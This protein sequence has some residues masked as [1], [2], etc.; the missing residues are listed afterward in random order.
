MLLVKLSDGRQLKCTYYHN[1]LLSVNYWGK[2]KL[3]KANELKIG[4]KIAKYQFPTI[5]SGENFNQAYS[6]GFYS[7]EGNENTKTVWIYEPKFICSKRLDGKL[8]ES[9]YEI[10]SG[11]KRKQF[12]LSFNPL[13]KDYV[14]LN[15]DLKSKINWLSGLFDGDGCELK[16]GGLQLVSVNKNFLLELQK[17]LSL[18]GTQCKVVFGSDEQYRSMP[19]GHGGEKQYLCKE[20]WRICIGAQQV[21][22]LSSLGLKCERLKFNK[23]P[24]RDASQFVKIVSIEALVYCFNE[25]I[26]HLGCF[27]GIVTG[28]CFEIGF[29]P[30]TNDGICGVMFCNLTSQNAAKIKTKVDWKIAI[31]A[32][33]IIGTLQAGYTDFKYLGHI[34]KELTKEEALL[35]VSVTGIMDNPELILNEEVQ[36]EM[37]LYACK[38]N[39]KWASKIGIN[40]SARITC[41]KPEGTSSLALSASSGIHPHHAKRYFRRVQC[42]KMDNVYKFFKKQNPHMCE[43]SVWSATKTDDIICFPIEV[44]DKCMVKDD[45]TAIQHLKYILSTQKNYVNNGTTEFNKKPITHNVSCTVKVKENEWE[46]VM[47][48]IYDNKDGF[49]AVSLIPDSLDKAYRQAPMEKILP[50]DEEKWNNIINNMKTVDY[51]QMIE[52]E[53]YTELKQ[54][55]ACGDGKCD[56]VY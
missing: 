49:A 46:E 22:Q 14:P 45:L 55:I 40:P 36:K 51:S 6:Q 24:N 9:T 42:N 21:Q 48:F 39:K 43:E 44:S 26:K 15:W 3:V 2:T 18:C 1:W 37:A 35:G 56:L 7:A 29:I 28:Q 47:K 53:D 52:N 41:V 34:S 17:L 13:P 16:E 32:A 50:E 38:I 31:K 30:V 5:L 54:V 12:T 27:N 8:S 10:H 11:I 25:P 4:D 33:T 19:N 20:S 23:T